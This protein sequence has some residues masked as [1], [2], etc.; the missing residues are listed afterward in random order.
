M[1]KEDYDTL[2]EHVKKNA[3]PKKLVKHLSEM[4][5]ATKWRCVYGKSV[6]GNKIM[7]VEFYDRTNCRHE[8]SIITERL[9]KNKED[10][11]NLS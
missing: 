10:E 7:G 1:S 4:I 3:N 11:N 6:S 8:Y 9:N 2:I 5:G